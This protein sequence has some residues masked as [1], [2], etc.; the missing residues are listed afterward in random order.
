MSVW[1]GEADGEGVAPGFGICMSCCAGDACGSAAGELAGIGVSGECL[2]CGGVAGN[3]DAA[4]DVVGDGITIP[5]GCSAWRG[6]DGP[7]AGLA[8][9]GLRTRAFRFGFRFALRL[10]ATF[11][12]ALLTLGMVWPSCWASSVGATDINNRRAKDQIIACLDVDSFFFITISL[13]NGSAAVLPRSAKAGRMYPR[14]SASSS[15]TACVRYS[16]LPLFLLVLF[17]FH[18]DVARVATTAAATI[19]VRMV[20]CM[21]FLRVVCHRA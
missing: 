20:F 14:N 8:G 5:G 18:L 15:R 19:L 7:L 9:C 1:C 12:F 3:V 2:V 16:L 6:V 17:V 11:G 4:G 21:L 10:G 13:L